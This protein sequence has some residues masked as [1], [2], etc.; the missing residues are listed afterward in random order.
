MKNESLTSKS[1]S[2]A[3]GWPMQWLRGRC[4]TNWYQG[5]RSYVWYL[6]SYTKWCHS[7]ICGGVHQKWRFKPQPSTPMQAFASMRSTPFMEIDDKGGEIVQRYE[8]F[9]K[10]WDKEI[11]VG[12]GH[13]Q[14]GEATLKDVK[15]SK[16][17]DKRSTQVG[18]AS[19]WTL[20]DCIWYVH[21]HVLACIA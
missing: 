8:S 7:N 21:I 14:R 1:S 3:N 16:F 10:D 15:R 5:Q 18:G 2:L 9:G 13:K 19:S 12:H 11:E 20:I 4:P 17:L 6:K